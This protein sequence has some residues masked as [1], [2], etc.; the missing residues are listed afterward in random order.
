MVLVTRTPKNRIYKA[1]HVEVHGLSRFF[2]LAEKAAF[3]HEISKYL[4]VATFPTNLW[5]PIKLGELP[6]V[7]IAKSI[8]W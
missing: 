2:F 6:G 1:L 3:A 8:V 5:V 4:E 7:I